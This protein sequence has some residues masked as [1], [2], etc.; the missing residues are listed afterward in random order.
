M[1]SPAGRFRAVPPAERADLPLWL[2]ADLTPL[3]APAV[4]AEPAAVAPTVPPAAVIAHSAAHATDAVEVDRVVP[5]SGTLQVAGQQFG[6]ARSAPGSRSSCGSA[7]PPCTS[8]WPG[9]T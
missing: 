9:N 8:R 4:P 1:A 6:S 2:P 3:P 7:P 5:A